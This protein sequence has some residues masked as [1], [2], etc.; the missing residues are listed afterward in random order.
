MVSEHLKTSDSTFPKILVYDLETSPFLIEAWGTYDTNALRV[1]RESYILTFAWKWYGKGKPQCLGLPDFDLYKSEPHNDRELVKKLHSLF[2]EADILLAHN[3]DRFDRRKANARF[4]KHG[5][6][7]PAPCQ[8]IDTLKIARK[9]FQNPSNRLDE[10]GKLLGV[11]RKV[12]H[13]GKHLWFDCIDG[14]S[15]AWKTMKKYNRQDVTLLENVYDKL[16]PWADTHPNLN[17]Y[18]LEGCPKCG[19]DSIQRRGVRVTGVSM[20]PRYTCNGCGTWFRGKDSIHVG[21]A[22]NG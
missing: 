4:L 22:R 14:D 18:A 11:G 20:Y 10:L 21:E 6:T 9:H 17:A 8:T 19:S 12:V 3:G 2:S 15:K 13:T 1:L 16:R 5:L 7:P